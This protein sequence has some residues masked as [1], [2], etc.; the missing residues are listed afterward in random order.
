MA[1]DVVAMARSRRS[2]HTASMRSA[3]G[4]TPGTPTRD[5]AFRVK[6]FPV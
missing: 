6:W 1:V 4:I 2:K 5:D 3:N